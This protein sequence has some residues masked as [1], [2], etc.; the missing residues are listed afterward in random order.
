MQSVIISVAVGLLAFVMGLV[1]LYLKRRLPERHMSTGSR[2]MIGAIMGLLS[3]LLALVLGT[4]VGS[5]HQFFTSQKAELESLGARSLELEL[6]FRQYGPETE[7]LRQMMK[8]S[9]QEASDA[10]QGNRKAYEQHFEIGDYLSKSRSGMTWSL[11]SP[12]T[13]RCRLSFSPPS[14]QFQPRSSRPG[15]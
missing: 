8:T 3:L 4:L 5:A 2:D 7:P 14:G 9:V 13:P 1:G 11:P 15:S 12:R 10:A 6:A